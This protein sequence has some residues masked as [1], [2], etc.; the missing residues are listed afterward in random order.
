MC[1]PPRWLTAAGYSC[2][3]GF[4]SL[5]ISWM[6]SDFP[7]WMDQVKVKLSFVQHSFIR[8]RLCR[9]EKSNWQVLKWSD[10]LPQWHSRPLKSS[11][12]Q[13]HLQDAYAVSSICPRLSVVFSC[14]SIEKYPS[15]F[16]CKDTEEDIS[17]LNK[18][19]FWCDIET[20]I[21]FTYLETWLRFSGNRVYIIDLFHRWHFDLS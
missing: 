18:V 7:F 9:H 3:V 12:V 1:P 8:K 6:E 4:C 14:W 16:F 20:K 2:S 17:G 19:S 5:T 13:L 10:R 11:P 15:V 21:V